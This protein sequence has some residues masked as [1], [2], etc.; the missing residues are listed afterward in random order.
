[1]NY[2]NLEDLKKYTKE[3]SKVDKIAYPWLIKNFVDHDAKFLF[4]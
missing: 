4:V 1:M 2:L 3:K